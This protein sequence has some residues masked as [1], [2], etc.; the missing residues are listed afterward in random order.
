[1]NHRREQAK[2]ALAHFQETSENEQAD[3]FVIFFVRGELWVRSCEMA[4]TSDW[5]TF[6]SRVSEW[7]FVEIGWYCNDHGIDSK[8]MTEIVN[9]I[10]PDVYHLML[11]SGVLWPLDEQCYEQVKASTDR[12]DRQFAFLMKGMDEY[13]VDQALRLRI[14]E[15]HGWQ[16]VNPFTWRGRDGSGSM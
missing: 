3:L 13:R 9:A 12:R 7:A 2:Q 4:L 14:A 15:V 16:I 5:R 11:S 6:W 1:M 8:G 10:K